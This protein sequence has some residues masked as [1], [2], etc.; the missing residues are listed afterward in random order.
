V[1]KARLAGS[2]DVLKS[3]LADDVLEIPTT[4]WESAAALNW[5]LGG[6]TDGN[7]EWLSERILSDYGFGGVPRQRPVLDEPP[8]FGDVRE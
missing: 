5:S 6:R 7:R 2:F 1:K 8:P 4:D 3:A